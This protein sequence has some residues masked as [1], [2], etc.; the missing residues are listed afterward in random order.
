MFVLLLFSKKTEGSFFLLNF[1]I[2]IFSS[3]GTQTRRRKVLWDDVQR[4]RSSHHQ[5][6]AADDH[7]STMSCSH[8][9]E[10]RDCTIQA[11]FQWQIQNK[12][13]CFPSSKSLTCGQGTR[14][15]LYACVD[16]NGVRKK[17]LLAL[18]N[19]DFVFFHNM[20]CE[21]PFASISIHVYVV[22]KSQKQW[23]REQLQE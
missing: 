22:N 10:S 17:A 8:L 5:L 1:Y 4:R 3:T 18:R 2:Y 9:A 23:A 6:I 19:V 16:H 13:E 14:K 12:E 21:S 7:F 11:C 15:L 20:A